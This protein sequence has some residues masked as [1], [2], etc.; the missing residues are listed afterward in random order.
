M[1]IDVA[2]TDYEYIVPLIPLI[3][4]VNITGDIVGLDGCYTKPSSG[5]VDWENA[6]DTLTQNIN[7]VTQTIPIY[8]NSVFNNTDA[9]SG[10]YQIEIDAGINKSNIKG[11]DTNNNKIKAIISKF[12]A[13]NAY[14]SAYSEGSITYEHTSNEPIE[15]SQF[16]IR[17]LD[18][19]GQLV[20]LN[21]Q[22]GTDSTV[23]MEIIRGSNQGN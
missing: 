1:T 14:T 6:P 21:E 4:G 7:I 17:V 22:L 15:L 23:F 5:F 16:R 12:Y 18:S 11:Q 3:D 2:G 9:Q 19:T 10:Y 20:S 13:Q 8:G